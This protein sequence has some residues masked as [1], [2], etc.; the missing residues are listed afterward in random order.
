MV[1]L[2]IRY[3]R[4]HMNSALANLSSIALFL[5]AQGLNLYIERLAWNYLVSKFV[6]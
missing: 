1:Y 5:S 4:K 6:W 3:Q 2:A